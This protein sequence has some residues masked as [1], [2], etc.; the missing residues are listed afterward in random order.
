M[1]LETSPLYVYFGRWVDANE[2]IRRHGLTSDAVALAHVE[3]TP[4]RIEQT[5]R[6]IVFIRAKSPA[7]SGLDLQRWQ[8]V[9]AQG[10]QR[11]EDNGFGATEVDYV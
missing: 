3:G 2:F 1:T 6:Q 5:N 9:A 8:E 11:N 7:P 4:L 10:R